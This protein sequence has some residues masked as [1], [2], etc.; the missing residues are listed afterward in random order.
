MI[1]RILHIYVDSMCGM[2][3]CDLIHRGFKI[4]KVGYRVHNIVQLTMFSP[5]LFLPSNCHAL[6]GSTLLTAIHV[7]LP[8]M[9]FRGIDDDNRLERSL[10]FGSKKTT[11]NIPQPKSVQ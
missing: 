7:V 6:P 1:S 11:H 2:N 10:N 3:V 4:A 5:T 9:L 8:H